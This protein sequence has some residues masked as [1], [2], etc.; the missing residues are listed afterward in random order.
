MDCADDASQAVA[1]VWPEI[2]TPGRQMAPGAAELRCAFLTH[3]VYRVNN[4]H[5]KA[6][7]E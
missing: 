7:D 4:F 3:Q 1:F 5:H 2:Q 6:L